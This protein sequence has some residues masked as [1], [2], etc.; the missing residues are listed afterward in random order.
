[1][2]ESILHQIAARRR[3]RIRDQGHE[4]GVTLPASRTVA[5]VPFGV[6]PF[7]ICEVKRRSPS[8]G[9]IAPGRD[10]VEQARVY[11]AAGVR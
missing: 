10:A 3:E 6:D 1:M 9:A 8:R 2:S 4:M 7:L 5:T 11:A